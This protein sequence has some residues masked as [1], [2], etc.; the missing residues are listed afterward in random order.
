MTLL[1][2]SGVLWG[3][4]LLW[5]TDDPAAPPGFLD[6]QVKLADLI[7][8]ADTPFA[9][10]R[11]DP[12][13]EA[14]VLVTDQARGQVQG[15]FPAVGRFGGR[16]IEFTVN[17]LEATRNAA[18]ADLQALSATFQPTGDI[19][20]LI[21]KEGGNTYRLNGQTRGVS[22]DTSQAHQGVIHCTIRFLATDPNV[23]SDDRHSVNVTA[24]TRGDVAVPLSV[25]LDWSPDPGTESATVANAGTGG[26]FWRA[27]ITGPAQDPSIEN[28]ATGDVVRFSGV[29]ASGDSVLLDSELRTAVVD[30]GSQVTL[31]APTPWWEFPPGSTVVV[32]RGG[33]PDL[34]LTWRDAWTP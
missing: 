12:W 4:G 21:W 20:S 27:Q 10:E 23:L 17:I 11:F 25:P 9:L 24:R 7:M 30:G 19:V 16:R 15:A 5:G 14:E 2:G 29:V 33:G 22:A 3:S 13:G 32:Y 28:T 1:W 18:L 6:G 34:L 8:G 26:T 31:V